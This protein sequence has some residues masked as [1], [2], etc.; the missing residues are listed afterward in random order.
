MKDSVEMKSCHNITCRDWHKTIFTMTE[1]SIIATVET[2][3]EGN[4]KETSTINKMKE[5]G[6]I[7]K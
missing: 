6:L 4:I 1:D 5:N 3:E 2:I 7:I